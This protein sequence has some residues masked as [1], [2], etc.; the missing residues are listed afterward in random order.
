MSWPAKVPCRRSYPQ[1]ALGGVR[2]KGMGV[3]CD[4]QLVEAHGN[5]HVVIL[6]RRIAREL[7]VEDGTD[8][9]EVDL[10]THPAALALRPSRW[11]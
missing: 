10:A 6:L 1:I 9:P 7:A 2:L 4:C 5:P 3:T 8:T 11:L